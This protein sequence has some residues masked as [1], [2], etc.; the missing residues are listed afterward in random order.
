[1]KTFLF[2][3]LSGICGVVLLLIL[4]EIVLRFLPVNEG[5]YLLP[6]NEKNPI[7]RF[8]PRRTFI[9]SKGWAFSI[10]NKVRTN[11]YGFVSDIDYEENSP[12]P[13]IA[14]IGDSYVA[15]MVPFYETLSG[16]LAEY[17]RDTFRIYSFARSGAPLSQYL[18]YS[19]Y[20]KTTFKPCGLVIVVVGNGFDESLMEYAYESGHH[21]FIKNAEGEWVLKRNDYSPGVAKKIFRMSALARYLWINLE[22]KSIPQRIECMLGKDNPYGQYVGQTP[23]VPDPI[24]TA[25]S[26]SAID[27]FFR[28]L[29]SMSGLDPS[30]ILFVID[31]IRPHL[32]HEDKL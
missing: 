8:E 11:N 18:I 25:K 20:V 23:S 29:P 6:V 24:R 14:I 10:V 2:K 9:W 3:V 32:Y 16:R 22:L 31:G 1:M 30:K 15:I 5:S 12:I 4:M 19:E 26:K 13:L 28:K 17:L 7:W 21:H 27:T